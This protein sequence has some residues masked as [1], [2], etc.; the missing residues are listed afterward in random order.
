MRSRGENSRYRHKRGDQTAGSQEKRYG[1]D[2]GVNSE[3][4]LDTL[5]KQYEG[6]YLSKT[7]ERQAK[8]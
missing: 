1:S 2:F 6:Q 8:E 7:K 4:K 3:I 5:R